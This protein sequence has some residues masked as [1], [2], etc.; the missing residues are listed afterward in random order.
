M[1]TGDRR[2]R[3]VWHERMTNDV[4]STLRYYESVVGWKSER[5]PDNPDYTLLVGAKGPSAGV[6]VL[7][8]DARAMGAPP[9]WLSYIE[10]GD[11]DSSVARATEFGA[12][13][14]V[15]AQDIPKVG[16][17]A[18]LQD[19]FGATFAVYTPSGPPMS[20]D[21]MALGSFSWHE[22]TTTDPE[23]ALGFY[24]RMF[25]W[26]ELTRMPMGP[27]GDYL[28]FGTAGV[29]LGGIYRKPAQ[30]PGPPSW[31]PYANV[32]DCK[33]AAGLIASRGGSVTNGPMEVPGG[34]WIVQ[35]IDPEGVMFALHAPAKAARA[36]NAS[37][38]A[39]Q[40]AGR[41]TT[42]KKPAKKP[43]KKAA[44]RKPVKRKPLKR[45]PAK[46]AP[47]RKV[48]ARRK[49]KPARRKPAARRRPAKKK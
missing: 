7:S 16:R 25:G 4:P 23:A 1:S 5:W 34:T 32:A 20:G 44:A 41:K 15:P 17:F 47:R 6:M 9:H 46:K 27:E 33:R 3:F 12:R 43:A 2:G 35:G 11:V 37:P 45:K 22:L 36:K 40:A 19:P 14:L 29:Q 38:G 30:L 39:K 42:K 49:A 28:I 21:D 18:V 10:V 26:E 13:V 24:A 8:D 31:L 48:A